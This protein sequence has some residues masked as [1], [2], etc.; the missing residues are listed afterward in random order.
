MSLFVKAGLDEEAALVQAR[1]SRILR[2][3]DFD[4]KA[5][6]PI[7]WK[8]TPYRCPNVGPGGPYCSLGDGCTCN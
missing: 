6:Q 4:F 3:S 8:P 7:L 1:V 2:A 5:K